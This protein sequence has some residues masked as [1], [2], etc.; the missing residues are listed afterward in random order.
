MYKRKVG[1]YILPTDY[2][3]TGVRVVYKN[4]LNTDTIGM[5]GNHIIFNC[6]ITNETVSKI[7]E[8]I[9]Q[10]SESYNIH[11]ISNCIYLHIGS[12]GGSLD[13][14]NI[15]ITTKNTVYPNLEII[16]VIEKNCNDAGFLLAALCDYR[17]IKKNAICSMSVLNSDTKYWG[18]YIQGDNIKEKLEFIFDKSKY[19]VKKEKFMNYLSS[20]NTFK[21]RKM[22][23]MGLIDEIY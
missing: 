11:K 1:D 17:I 20:N 22:L 10:I 23:K 7:F 21:C 5:I 18:A 8:T 19:K 13:S 6:N 12:F 14:L 2:D 15:F 16:S 9:K 4:P 3:T